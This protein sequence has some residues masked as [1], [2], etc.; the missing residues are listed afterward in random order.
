MLLMYDVMKLTKGEDYI[1]LR[2]IRPEVHTCGP[3]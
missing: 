3:G 2:C 1:E